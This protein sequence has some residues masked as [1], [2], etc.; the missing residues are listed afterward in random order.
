[1]CA[2]V[3]S[4]GVGVCDGLSVCAHACVCVCVCLCVCVRVWVGY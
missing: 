2:W 3:K 4:A 1:V